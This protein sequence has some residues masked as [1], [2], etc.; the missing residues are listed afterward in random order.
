MRSRLAECLVGLLYFALAAGT[1][2]LNG[3]NG[4]IATLWPPT[5]SSSPSCSTA[6]RARGRGFCARGYLADV[7]ANAWSY[8]L[9]REHVSPRGLRPRRG[10]HRRRPDAAGRAGQGDDLLGK[11]A[12]AVRF[13]VVCGLVGARLGAL[14]GAIVDRLLSGDDLWQSFNDWLLSS[15]LGLVIFTPVLLAGFRGDYRRFILGP[16]PPRTRRGRRPPGPDGPGRGRGVSSSPSGRHG[17]AVRSVLLVTF[18]T[19]PLGD[20][21]GGGDRRRH[22]ALRR[23]SPTR[24]RSP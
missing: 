24:E 20:E 4:E 8:G 19:G 11:P 13:L 14:G 7:A 1:I 23:S 12:V 10:L 5:P 21:A 3:I 2:H 18:R 6:G 22:S 17:A 16:G 9:A 15:G